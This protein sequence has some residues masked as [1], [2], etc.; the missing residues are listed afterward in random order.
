[1]A[2]ATPRADAAIKQEARAMQAAM[3]QKPALTGRYL[4]RKD[5]GGVFTWT[6]E[7]HATGEFELLPEDYLETVVE[8]TSA[9]AKKRTPKNKE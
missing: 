7:L 5:N 8:A 4:R 3:Q 1:M 9:P 6:P 2:T